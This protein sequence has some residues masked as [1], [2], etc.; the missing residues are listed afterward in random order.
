MTGPSFFHLL[1]ES[2]TVE[3]P[4]SWDDPAAARL[5]RYHL[6]YFDDLNAENAARRKSWHEALI[7]RWISENPPGTGT[8]WEPY[9]VSRR[10]VNWI[11]WQ[12]AGNALSEEAVQ[13]LAVQARWLEKRLE[14]HLLGNHL[15]ANAKALFFAGA[16][17]GG[18]EGDRWLKKGREIGKKQTAEQVLPDGGHFEG[19][20]MYHALVLGDLLDLANLCR[21]YGLAVPEEWEE[22]CGRMLDWLKVM[23]HPD[24]GIALFNDAA[25]GMAPSWKDLADYAE[26]LGVR[27]RD[28]G[29]GPMAQLPDTG[30]VRCGN[31]SAVLFVDAGPVGPDYIPGHAHADTLGFE[32]SLFGQRLI[33]DSGTSTYE[34]TPER[35]RQRGTAAHNT[36]MIDGR[37]SSE[38]WGGFRVGRRARPFDVR[39]GEEDG[40][41][42]VACSHD[43]YL[44]LSGSPVHRREYILEESCLRVRDRIRGGFET[45]AARFHFHP[46]VAFTMIEA[47]RGK[48]R[49]PGGEP[50]S[51]H[52]EKGVARLVGSTWHPEF[53]KSIPS[54]CLEVSLSGAVAEVVLSWNR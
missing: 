2:R 35:K 10:I 50:F 16:F 51:I 19:S 12:M 8:G 39:A 34:K 40:A 14:W 32:F 6:H 41:L 46:D 23:T 7:R 48:G 17:F 20:P 43:G 4:W 53:G 11:K 15:L 26:R 30:Y 28:K 18:S 3:G 36:V 47:G 52:V 21:T 1:N 45:A 33:V 49:L 24:G 22:A 37:D 9:P 5:W 25:F 42:R 29:P 38:V 13:S 54:L 27:G 31:R 44:R